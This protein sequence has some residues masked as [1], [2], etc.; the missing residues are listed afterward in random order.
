MKY[1]FI[2]E[3]ETGQENQELVVDCIEE[4]L[5]YFATDPFDSVKITPCSDK[6]E[7]QQK[8]SENT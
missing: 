4:T 3:I 5:D 2:I 6:E 8:P 1:K 7:I